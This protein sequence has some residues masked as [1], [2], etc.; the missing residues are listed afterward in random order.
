M[1]D[2][3]RYRNKEEVKKWEDEDPI[4]IFR[5]YLVKE[6]I[7]TDEALDEQDD[8][9]EKIVEEAVEFAENSPNPEK[10]TLF[11]HI[12]VE[13]TPVEYRGYRLE[14]ESEEK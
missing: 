9:A 1:G 13:E 12:Y 5:K 7:S 14:N 8:L 4:G 2:P 6:D 10:E 11:E 3:E